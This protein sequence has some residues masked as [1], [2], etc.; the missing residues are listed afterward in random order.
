M[1]TP[2]G[3]HHLAFGLVTFALGVDGIEIDAA[4]QW[5]YYAAMTHDTLYRV[6]LAA[7]LDTQADDAAL[8]AKVETVGARPMSDGFTPD[9]EGRLV[10][11]RRRQRRTSVTSALP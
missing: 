10:F 7:L 11:D 8:A 5:L 6:P 1:C 9:R 2:F 3:P 4:G